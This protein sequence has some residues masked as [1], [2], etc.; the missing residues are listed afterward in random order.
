MAITVAQY[1]SWMIGT[2]YTMAITVSQPRNFSF[3]TVYEIYIGTLNCEFLNFK[4][5]QKAQQI[6]IVQIHCIVQALQ[7]IF[8]SACVQ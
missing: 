8:I 7:F 1:Y 5:L 6:I 2:Y 4:V 3:I